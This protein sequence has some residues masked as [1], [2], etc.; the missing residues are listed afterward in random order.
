MYI[1]SEYALCVGVALAV[2]TFLF[3]LCA[4]FLLLQE[5]IRH[6]RLLVEQTVTQAWRLALQ[7]LVLQPMPTTD[8]L[9]LNAKQL[10]H[11]PVSA[12]AAE[13]PAGA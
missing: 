12:G 13:L 3:G 11:C 7:A 2:A 9:S 8:R 10:E 4:V 1:L 5:G 6:L